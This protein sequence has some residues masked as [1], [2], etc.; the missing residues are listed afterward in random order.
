MTFR[1]RLSQPMT[2]T[3]AWACLFLNILATPGLGTLIARRFISGTIQVACAVVGF[4]LFLGWFVQKMR[5]LYGQVFGTNLPVDAGS[6]LGKWALIF[7]GSA[8][9]WS[10]IT[11]LQIF[12]SVPKAAALADLPPKIG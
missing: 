1:E 10:L 12:R 5:L 9:V 8:W 7:F 4:L 2:S 11:S 3:K 6:S